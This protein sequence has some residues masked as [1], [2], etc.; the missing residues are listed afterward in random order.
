M[1]DEVLREAVALLDLHY[2]QFYAVVPYADTTEHPVP[3]DT[4]G[5][6][7]ILVSILTKKKGRK[8][9]K[10]SDLVDGS[11]VKA[12]NI[13]NAIDTPRFNGVLKAGTKANSAGKLESLDSTPFL[14]FVLW[15][16]V[17]NLETNP[18]RCRI[19][20]VR[21]QH[22]KLFREMAGKWFGATGA[23]NFQL[24]PP[25]SLTSETN[26]IRNNLGTFEYP[27]LFSAIRKSKTSTYEVD[28]FKPD[29]LC[30]GLLASPSANKQGAP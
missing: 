24:H 6:S 7:Q 12:A 5:W 27:L 25:R 22:D 19:W 17:E 20:F 16:H 21:P 26:I 9:K 15:D 13:W 23:K 2:D 11:D 28:H 14:F 1:P 29:L 8:R 30:T 18:A 10:G 4:R 3:T